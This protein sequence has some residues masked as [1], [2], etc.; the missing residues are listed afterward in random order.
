MLPNQ[1]VTTNIMP[2]PSYGHP[3]NHPLDIDKLLAEYKEKAASTR[4]RNPCVF[5]VPPF[6]RK[7]KPQIYDASF[8]PMGL[9]NRKF[10]EGVS[11]V[12]Q[13]KREVL[14]CF[15]K[16]LQIDQN[17]WKTFCHE[18]ATQP[19]GS[20]MPDL[21]DFYEND[22]TYSFLTL[23][24]RQSIL[25]TDAFFI[26]AFF[27][28]KMD[29]Q[30]EGMWM[31]DG[32]SQPLVRHIMQIFRSGRVRSSHGVMNR[33]I[34]WLW[35]GQIPLFLVKNV[36]ERVATLAKSG[37]R[38]KGVANAVLGEVR[39]VKLFFHLSITV[40]LPRILVDDFTE[41]LLLNLSLYESMNSKDEGVNEWV[42]LMDE[43]INTEEDV[44]LL[45]GGRDPV[46]KQNN[47][48]DKKRIVDI[49]TNT[50]DGFCF[51][52]ERKC[53]RIVTVRHEIIMWYNTSWRRAMVSFL[54]KFRLAPWLLVSLLAAVALLILTF[55]QTIYT[56]LGFK[57]R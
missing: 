54:D 21:K 9:L 52:P 46:I 47:L 33:D 23:E 16:H 51:N 24:S 12:D 27:I 41:T 36:W 44:E 57:N 20:N 40:Y 31:L 50:L 6:I 4:R 29:A 25:V 3:W 34:F 35:E 37:I 28:W 15:L 45:M 5:H 26:V 2:P 10:V 53:S 39:L 49:F 30:G 11:S 13:L 43:L 14:S 42:V 32:R 18:V 7:L 38:F 56:I 8:L 1:P 22:G 55:L 48:G 17:G 19:S